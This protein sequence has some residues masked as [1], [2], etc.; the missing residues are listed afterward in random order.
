MPGQLRIGELAQCTGKSIH[1]L[2]YYESIGL[3]PFVTRDARGRRQY[4]PQHVEWLL[5]LDRLQRTGMSLSQMQEYAALVA[6]GRQTIRQ[7]VRLLEA[8]LQKIDQQMEDLAR[9]RALLIAKLDF[10]RE[11]TSSGKR[12]ALPWMTLPA[13]PRQ[14]SPTPALRTARGRRKGAA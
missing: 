11:W 8:H 7:R 5:L 3:M 2:R 6:Q 13:V 10:Y 9:S 4:D 14:A 1:T 12:P